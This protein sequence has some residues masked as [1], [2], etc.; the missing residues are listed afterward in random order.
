M[1]K[2]K[3]KRLTYGDVLPTTLELTKALNDAAQQNLNNAIVSL[4]RIKILMNDAIKHLVE[5]DAD[6]NAA[7]DDYLEELAKEKSKCPSPK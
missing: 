3:I 6:A 5:C 2:K 4:A 7:R 1:R